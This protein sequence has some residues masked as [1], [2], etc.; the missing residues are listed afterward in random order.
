ML[1]V[2]RVGDDAAVL[3]LD[4]ARGLAGDA[5]VVRHQDERHVLLAAE[6]HD[7]FE[8][9]GRAFSLSRL[10]VGSSASRTDGAIGEAAGD[11]DA[12]AFSAGELGGKMMQTRFE[13]DGFQQFDGRRFSLA[14]RSGAFQTSGSAR[15][16]PR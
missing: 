12:L 6:T 5:Q 4:D 14:R 16:R 7:Q 9:A 8:D 11:G 1:G 2:E 3:H 15:S 10:P 13:S